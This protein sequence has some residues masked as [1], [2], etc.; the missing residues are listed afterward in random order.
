MNDKACNHHENFQKLWR[1]IEL[2]KSY[3][4]GYWRW[5][6]SY[7]QRQQQ[8]G[9]GGGGE[10]EGVHGGVHTGT[11]LY[12]TVLYCTVLYTLY[13][14]YCTVLSIQA[15]EPAIKMVRFSLEKENSS[16][17]G[18]SY[19]SRLKSKVSRYICRYLVSSPS[20][21][22]PAQAQAFLQAPLQLL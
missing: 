8:R 11:V 9:G 21:G 20:Q 14:L 16:V 19:K 22:C 4:P 13:T 1:T 12:C 10:G 2:N 18:S 17:R 7:G 3:D 5:R 15:G 6:Q